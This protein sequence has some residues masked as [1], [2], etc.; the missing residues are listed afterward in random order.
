MRYSIY[1]AADSQ[2]IVCLTA[3]ASTCIRLRIHEQAKVTT[4]RIMKKVLSLLSADLDF[5]WLFWGRMRAATA[6]LNAR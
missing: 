2:M 3:D 5:L 4:A 6:V 1:I